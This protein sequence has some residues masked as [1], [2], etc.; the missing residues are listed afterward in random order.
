MNSRL[1]V[2]TRTTVSSNTTGPRDL[3]LRAA[4]VA[5]GFV[6]T[7]MEGHEQ[8]FPAPGHALPETR[9]LPEDTQPDTQQQD[10]SR[11]I[12]SRIVNTTRAAWRKATGAASGNPVP[13]TLAASPR[14]ATRPSWSAVS[15]DIDGQDIK[16]L[17]RG[18]GFADNEFRIHMEFQ[19]G[20]GCM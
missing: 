5:Q 3:Q 14:S 7:G 16:T 1:L 20:W 18:L 9:H 2:R 12:I 6:M 19:R 8:P 15:H 4:L 11:S 13:G 17:L 10:R